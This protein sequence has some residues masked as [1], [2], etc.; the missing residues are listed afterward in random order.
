MKLRDLLDRVRE[1]RTD[2]SRG[3]AAAVSAV[4]FIVG[5]LLGVLQ[6]R[7]DG[8]A[9]NELPLILQRIDIV[10]FFGRLAIWI[11]LGT[12]IAVF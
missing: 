10:N 2:Y 3:A 12:A 1:P 6:K 7:L 11:L 9:V 8:T 5:A 4:L